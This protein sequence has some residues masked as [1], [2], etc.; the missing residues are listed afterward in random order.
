MGQK[1]KFKK[2]F[3][4]RPHCKPAANL[5]C[6]RSKSIKIR[7]QFLGGFRLGPDLEYQIDDQVL[8]KKSIKE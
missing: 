8:I 3:D 7:Q 2:S 4:Y 1:I 6:F 5:S